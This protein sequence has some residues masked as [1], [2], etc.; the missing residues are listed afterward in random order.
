MRGER[1]QGQYIGT[2]PK[3]LAKGAL[4]VKFMAISGTQDSQEAEALGGKALGVNYR[5]EEDVIWFK[6]LPMFYEA[7]G[8][9]SDQSR[10]MVVLDKRAIKRLAN[11]ALTFSR[12]QALSMV[13]G[14][15]DPLGLAS[16]ALM[17]GKL[18]L[19]RLYSVSI[20]SGWDADLPVGEKSLWAAWFNELLD[21][22]EIICPRSTRYP[23]EVET[24]RLAGFGNAS[25]VGLC[26]AV[27]VIWMDKQGLGHPR[28]LLA[29]CRVAPLR[30]MTIPRGE[31]Q[32]LVILHC[33]L[34]VVAE[35]F[36][37]PLMSISA[38]T[39][40]LCSLG[41]LNKAGN[42]MKPYFSNRVSEIGRVRDQLRALTEVL[43]DMFSISQMGQTLQTLALEDR[44]A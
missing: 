44:F 21:A 5:L 24:V 33:L 41:A 35:T 32:A 17:K 11:G 29:K 6:L 15:Y 20:K 39:D 16:P 1:V 27:Y 12:R 22:P 25:E 37:Y 13:M 42:T 4:Q 38:F 30:G 3:I 28:L 18:L 36:P 7:K 9:S 31:L 2:I 43:P 8:R 40:S 10:E 26:V 19:R 23:G 34:L 14:V